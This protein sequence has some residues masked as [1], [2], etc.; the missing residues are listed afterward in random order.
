[1]RKTV[2]NKKLFLALWTLLLVVY[3][4]NVR[5]QDTIIPDIIYSKNIKSVQLFRD[6]WRLSYPVIELY[7][8]LQLILKFDDLSDEIKNYNY[9]LIHCDS[10]WRPTNL[11]EAEYIEGMLQDQIDDYQYSFNTYNNYIHYTLKIP[12]DNMTFTISGNY[13]LIVFEGFDESNVAFIKRFMVTE[14]IVNVEANVTRPVLSAY[15]DIGHQV[16]LKINY[17]SFPLEDPYGD[18]RVVI[19]QNGRWDNAITDLKPLFD[20][21]GMLVYDYQMENVFL[22]GHE[23]RWFDIKSLRYQSP[24]IKDIVFEQE[25][26]YVELFPEENRSNKVYF[27]DEEING[28]F[29]AEVQEESNND[30]DAEYVYVDFTFPVEAPMVTGDFYVLGEL[31]NWDFNERNKMEYDLSSG[32]YKLRLFLKQGYYNYHIAFLEQG[33]N[34]ADLSYAEGNYYETEN[35]Y[36][37]FVYHYGTTS[38]YE[39]LIGYQ[40]I[41]SLRRE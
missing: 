38:R 14:K 34:T 22:A 27:F 20:R 9:R 10:D 40:I 1:M 28:K 41:N 26:F 8:D 15:R 2:Q 16:N 36:L 11:N 39:R 5:S 6:G 37:V 23:Y 31:T 35:D 25:D 32:S 7:S 12:N 17:A 18:I 33:K 13:A 4:F 24:Y 19:R 3:S 30:T 21:G 29:Y